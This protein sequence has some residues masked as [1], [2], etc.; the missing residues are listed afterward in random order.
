MGSFV[1]QDTVNSFIAGQTACHTATDAPCPRNSPAFTA[2]ALKTAGVANFPGPL[3]TLS[4]FW[5][6]VGY[7]FSL[8]MIVSLLL[9]LANVI[10]VS[11]IYNGSPLCPSLT[12]PNL[13][14]CC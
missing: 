4:T 7:V 14:R 8:L 11:F 6:S 2:Y 10:K 13:I 5:G 1:L 9:P 3:V 12:F